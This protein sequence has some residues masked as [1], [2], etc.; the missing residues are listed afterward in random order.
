MDAAEV[1]FGQARYV[2]RPKRNSTCLRIPDAG[3]VTS[4]AGPPMAR[5]SMRR[6]PMARS[7]LAKRD[8]TRAAP[9]TP[10]SG[11]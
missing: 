10:V 8:Y 7:A 4:H 3:T 9:T 5:M 2:H 6:W 11:R 1:F